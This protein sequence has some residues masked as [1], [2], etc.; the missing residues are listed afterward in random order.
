MGWLGVAASGRGHQPRHRAAAEAS[1][2]HQV[3][4]RFERR[5]NVIGAMAKGPNSVGQAR[6][7]RST[8]DSI[9]GGKLTLEI[10]GRNWWHA[11][12]RSAGSKERQL[13]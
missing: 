5:T 13:S 1:A 12:T 9:M 4:L 2:R 10:C 8:L 6:L 3:A 7:S 11:A